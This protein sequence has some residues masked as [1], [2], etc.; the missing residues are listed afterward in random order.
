[1]DSVSVNQVAE[2]V[3][4]VKRISGEAADILTSLPEAA[5]FTLVQHVSSA[6]PLAVGLLAAV[7][8]T[9]VS[10]LSRRFK[11]PE[12]W[13]IKHR[14]QCLRALHVVPQKPK[15]EPPKS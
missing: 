3:N 7:H 14:D 9:P 4:R 6:R 13:V 11:I 15:V 10:A 2:M 12:D 1:M 8:R 5:A